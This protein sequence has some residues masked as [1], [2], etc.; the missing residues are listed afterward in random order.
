MIS[1]DFLFELKYSI[2]EIF[3]FIVFLAALYRILNKELGISSKVRR[4]EK[5]LR[6]RCHLKRKPG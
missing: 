2:F 6:S 4:V 1:R 5:W 3:L